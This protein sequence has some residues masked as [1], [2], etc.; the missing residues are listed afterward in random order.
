RAIWIRGAVEPAYA[1]EA[2]KAIADELEQI[3]TGD[4][5]VLDDFVRARKHVLAAALAAPMGA[6]PRAAAL[7]QIVR[8]GGDVKQLD[9][10]IEAIRTLEFAAVQQIVARDMKPDRMITAVRGEKHAV[11]AALGALG[12]AKE[13]IEWF[14][15]ANAKGSDPLAP[16][17]MP[18]LTIRDDASAR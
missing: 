7:E 3:R 17:E 15:P 6:S 5:S 11:E 18:K 13:K 14:A 8:D 9:Q 16:V 2:A 12:I 4:T 1:A 10:S